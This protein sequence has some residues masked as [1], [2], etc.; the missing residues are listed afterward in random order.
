MFDMSSTSRYMGPKYVKEFG[1]RF[2]ICP[3]LEVRGA[4]YFQIFG[5]S[6]FDVS[7]FKVWWILL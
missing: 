3:Q 2:L 5:S 4:K 1:P 7:C 6:F